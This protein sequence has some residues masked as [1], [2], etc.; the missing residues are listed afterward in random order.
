MDQFSSK[1][2]GQNP[3]DCSVSQDVITWHSWLSPL[4]AL[5]LNRNGWICLN[6]LFLLI[7]LN[8]NS[9]SESSRNA[10]PASIN[11]FDS[12]HYFHPRD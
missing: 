5:H 8:S 3:E 11:R 10:S 4:A 2:G 9:I 12:W 1:T 6:C 7:L